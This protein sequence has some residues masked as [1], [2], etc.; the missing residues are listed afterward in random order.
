MDAAEAVADMMIGAPQFWIWAV[1]IPLLL[2]LWF[3]KIRRRPMTVGSTLLW[4]KALEDERVR[5]PFQRLIRNL[6]MLCQL[7]VLIFLIFAL[8]RPESGSLADSSRLNVLL[9]DRSASMNSVEEDGRTRFEH[10]REMLDQKLNEIAGERG[11]LISFGASAEALTPVTTD[12]SLLERAADR[13]SAG[14]G[15]TGFVEALELGLSF[16][17]Q[18]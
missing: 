14:V 18:D 12:L 3:L 13:M 16:V 4:Q 5:S 1:L 11:V 15:Q 10:A 8:L 17:R 6:L 2:L 9:M 7:L